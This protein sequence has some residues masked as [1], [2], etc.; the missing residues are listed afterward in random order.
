MPMLITT[1]STY[2]Y[3]FDLPDKIDPSI[4]EKA[5]SPISDYN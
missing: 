4:I 3:K 2:S 1:L 5:I